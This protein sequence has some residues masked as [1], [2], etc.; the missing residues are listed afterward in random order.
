M[1]ICWSASNRRF[2]SFFPLSPPFFFFFIKEKIEWKW[3]ETRVDILRGSLRRKSLFFI[4]LFPLFLFYPLFVLFIYLLVF[5]PVLFPDLEL[6][7]K[8]Q[9]Q[10]RNQDQMVY[11]YHSSEHFSFIFF[12]YFSFFFR[13]YFGGL[14]GVIRGR[15]FIPLCHHPLGHPLLLTCLYIIVAPSNCSCTILENHRLNMWWNFENCWKLE[16]RISLSI[17]INNTWYGYIS[18]EIFCWIYVAHL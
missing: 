16:M 17:V 10:N 3:K 4:F 18:L 5:Y 11:P 14:H 12:F 13:F 2:L 7:W 15:I 9:N 6:K 8:G 1:Y